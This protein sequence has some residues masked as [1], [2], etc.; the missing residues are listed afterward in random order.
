MKV[1]LFASAA[2]VLLSAIPGA[3]SA[4]VSSLSCF[5][6]F[7]AATHVP[8]TL[9]AFLLFAKMS[10]RPI[11]SKKQSLPLLTPVTLKRNRLPLKLN[12]LFVEPSSPQEQK[13]LPTKTK[14]SFRGIII[15]IRRMG[16]HGATK[17]LIGATT[18]TARKVALA[19][20]ETATCPT[21]QTIALAMGAT[22]TCPNAL[23]TA[24]A[25]EVSILLVLSS[26]SSR[27]ICS[28]PTSTSTSSY[29]NYPSMLFS[30]HLYRKL[31]NAHVYF[32]MLL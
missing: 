32:F 13:M 20:A 17:V 2:L 19:M 26:R 28:M 8:L 16:I 21:A 6:C 31:R 3:L 24:N 1:Q 7:Q 4:K 12:H 27:V 15:G 29:S 30:Q 25:P 23:T 10:Y 18:V 9:P 5:F 14:N 11:P 22:V